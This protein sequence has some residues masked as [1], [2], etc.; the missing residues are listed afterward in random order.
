MCGLAAYFSAAEPVPAEALRRAAEVLRHRGPDNQAVWIDPAGGAGL[1]HTRLSLL[2]LSANAHQPLASVNDRLRLVHN[3]EFY[4][5]E[6]IR[7]DCEARGHRFLTRCDSEI[8]LP[9]YE[10][11]GT[12][13]LQRLRGEFAFIIWDRTARRVFAARDRFGIK[14]L[15]YARCRDALCFAS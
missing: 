4:D 15:F 8:L 14:P 2:D 6:E 11:S 5:F 12:A 9:L 10:E 7:R 13:A 3:G 1:A